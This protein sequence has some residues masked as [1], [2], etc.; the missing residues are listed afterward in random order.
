MTKPTLEDILKIASFE[1][2]DEG[3]LIQTS[4]K[5]DFIGNHEGDHEGDHDG[6]HYGDH[7]GNHH[8]HHVGLHDGYHVG[9]PN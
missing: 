4:L 2:D 7:I 9:R 6:K 3:E 5:A 1:F 8:G